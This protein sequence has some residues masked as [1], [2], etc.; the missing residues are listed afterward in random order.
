MKSSLVLLFLVGVAFGAVFRSAPSVHP[1]IVEIFRQSD[2]PI[3]NINFLQI[4][5]ENVGYK[6]S[7]GPCY[8]ERLIRGSASVPSTTA[9]LIFH[10]PASPVERC[11]LMCQIVTSLKLIIQ[12]C[13]H[14]AALKWFVTTR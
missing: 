1:G 4:T 5:Q 11:P 12:N 10:I 3:K 2:L 7:T 14:T 13:I 6:A 8:R 9:R